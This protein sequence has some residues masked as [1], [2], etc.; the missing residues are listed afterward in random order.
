MA[1]QHYQGVRIDGAAFEVPDL[2]DFKIRDTGIR[3]RN[4]PRRLTA[5]ERL[6]GT[7]FDEK[8]YNERVKRGAFGDT[9]QRPEIRQFLSQL[10]NF[11]SS[12]DEDGGKFS[13]GCIR[14]FRPSFHPQFRD[15]VADAAFVQNG[16]Q[17][18]LSGPGVMVQSGSGR[19]GISRTISSTTSCVR[20]CRFLERRGKAMVL[21][22]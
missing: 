7:D 21:S 11:H 17:L 4:G 9:G 3:T 14:L 13:S 6:S 18:D 22:T 2:D 16:V 15:Y 20:R 8:W 10:L 1:Q 5:Y 12:E 19:R